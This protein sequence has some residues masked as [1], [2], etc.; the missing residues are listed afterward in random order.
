MTNQKL[1][2]HPAGRCARAEAIQ[3]LLFD[4]SRGRKV[5]YGLFG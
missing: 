4:T 2:R 5:V 3:I 1:T